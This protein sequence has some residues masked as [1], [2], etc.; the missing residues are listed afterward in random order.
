[1]IRKAQKEDINKLLEIENSVFSEYDFKLTK[2][3]FIY[4]QKKGH[5]YVVQDNDII[6][7]YFLFLEYKKSLRLY[8]IAVSKEFTNKGFGSKMIEYLIK[9]AHEKL[10]NII[11]EVKLDNTN[12]IN[13]YQ[14]YGF[15]KKKILRSYYLDGKDGI[16]MVLLKN[17][18][19]I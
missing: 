7:A 5:I 18:Q 6:C 17:L 13:L 12:A 11:L 3:C 10:K 16:K 15:M 1:M 14:K 9:L 2:R 4:H 19:K 8:S